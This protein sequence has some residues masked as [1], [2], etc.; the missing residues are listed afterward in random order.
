MLPAPFSSYASRLFCVIP[1]EFH[2]VYIPPEISRES[3]QNSVRTNINSSE[4]SISRNSSE[5]NSGVKSVVILA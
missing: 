5:R 1:V 3:S 2:L 4:F